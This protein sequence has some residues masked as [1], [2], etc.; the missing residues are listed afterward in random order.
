MAGSLVLFLFFA[1]GFAALTYQVIWQ[2][3]LTLATGLDLFAVTI[4]VAVFLAGIGL[5]NLVGGALA[6]RLAPA[7]RFV[8]FA[9]AEFVIAGFALISPW[10][11]GDVLQSGAAASLGSRGALLV[12]GSLLLLP[13]FC[14]GVTLPLLAR[15]VSDRL[16]DVP[17]WVGGLYGWNTLGAAAGAFLGTAFLVRNLGYGAALAW[18]AALNGTAGLVALGL[19]ARTGPAPQVPADRAVAP[20]PPATG[21][22]PVRNLFG[23]YFL[24]GFIALSL[25]LIWFRVLGVTLKSTAFTFPLLLATYL[26][27]VGAGSLLTRHAAASSREPLLVF[28]RLQ[29]AIPLYAGL[30]VAVLI[31]L[32]GMAGDTGLSALQQ[33]LA[34]YEPIP[35]NFDFGALSRGQ[36]ALYLGL[37]ALLVLLPTLLMGA[38]F[39]YLQ[40]A[41]HSSVA[42]V[43]RRVG[44]LQAANVAGCVLGVVLTGA[45]FL[46]VLGTTGALRLLVL[47]AAPFLWLAASARR[48]RPGTAGLVALL[49][50]AGVALLVPGQAAFWSALHGT[51]PERSIVAEDGTGLSVLVNDR[52][53]FRGPT[54][55]FVNGLGQSFVPFG[56][57]HTTL[58]LVPALLHP[59]P[60]D[61]AVIGLGSGDT[62]YASSARPETRRIDSIEINGAQLPTLRE[63]AA[64]TGYG[65]LSRLLE[66]P[67]VQHI[68]GDGRR[69]LLDATRRYDII[70]ADALR[71]TSAFAGNLYSRE[72]FQLLRQRLKPGGLAVTWVPTPRTLET[73]RAVFPHVA[74]F[75]FV[76]VGSNEPIVVVRDDIQR[77]ARLP[78]VEQH[79]LA[80][81]LNLAPY[82]AALLRDYQPLPQ[83]APQNLA[84]YNT[85]L[86]PRDE[87]GLP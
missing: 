34:S 30:S 18:A 64:R 20:D 27:G 7:R 63:L 56:G 37:P 69:H 3:L 51:G 16:L 55:V 85:D 1:S 32:L 22:T 42:T 39:P 66:D 65:G 75:D 35:F 6:D 41:A 48:G 9:A 12:G 74:R 49:L 70:E 45:V 11:L 57:G 62:L 54:T 80:A 71:P 24:S 46:N 86:F 67:R 84:G 83:G 23:L 40:R 43:G 76:L 25:E 47:L 10:L 21:T 33:Y 82:V 38:S 19:A 73:F 44:Q 4:I 81:D 58:G 15:T 29:S 28:L 87:L 36:L 72:Y 59:A 50:P 14:M 2:R 5:G 68:T 77:R 78:Q 17:K 52:S 13:T 53:D 8:A 60:V 61:V 79:F 31:G 26:A